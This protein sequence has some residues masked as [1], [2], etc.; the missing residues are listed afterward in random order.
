MCGA[1]DKTFREV[2]KGSKPVTIRFRWGTTIQ[3]V[4]PSCS[5]HTLLRRLCSHHSSPRARCLLLP[6]LQTPNPDSLNVKP[7]LLRLILK[8]LKLKAASELNRS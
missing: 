4:W 8:S 5:V 7:T 2:S 1:T 6:L 3:F